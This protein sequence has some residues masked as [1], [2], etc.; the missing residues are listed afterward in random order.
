VGETYMALE[1]DKGHAF[2]YTV[3][4]LRFRSIELL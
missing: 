4:K 1:K 2:V 3:M